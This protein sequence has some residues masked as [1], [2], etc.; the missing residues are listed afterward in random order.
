MDIPT[1]GERRLQATEA[2]VDR[3]L[4]EMDAEEEVGEE[5]ILQVQTFA[6]P[7]RLPS[8][9]A[10]SEPP[11]RQS[12]PSHGSGALVT[13]VNLTTLTIGHGLDS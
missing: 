10:L 13:R 2:R 9:A 3:I 8:Q 1:S 11:Q 7:R 12:V 4:A 5:E 6:L